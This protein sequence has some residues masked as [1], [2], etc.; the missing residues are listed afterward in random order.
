MAKEY[1]EREAL[2]NDLVEFTPYAVSPVYRNLNS[3][4]DMFTVIDVIDEQPAANVVEVVRCKDCKYW[5]E[6]G[7]FGDGE[8]GHLMGLFDVAKPDDFCSYGE[9]RISD[10]TN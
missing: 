9:R 10:E 5:I 6:I 2:K 4:I 1:I 3:N 8:C 7:E